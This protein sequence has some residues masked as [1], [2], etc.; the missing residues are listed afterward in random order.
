MNSVSPRHNRLKSLMPLIA[1]LACAAAQVHAQQGPELSGYQ[2]LPFTLSNAKSRIVPEDLDG[3]GL[4]DILTADEHLLSVYFQNADGQKPFDFSQADAVLAL[5]GNA[6]GW[7]I[8]KLPGHEN[9]GGKRVLALLE[10]QQVQAWTISAE[11]FGDAETV[12]GSVSG[13]LPSGA[14]PLGFVRDINGDGLNDLIV[15]GPS[16]LQLYL[17]TPEGDYGDS[18]QIQSRMINYARLS[19]GENLASRVGQR[20]RIPQMNIRDVNN[21]HRK[22]LIARSEARVDVFLAD[23]KGHFPTGANYS[24]DLQALKDRVGEVDFDKLDYSNLSGVLSHTYDVQL[25]DVDGDNIE[26]LLMREG[27]KL[28]LFGGTASGMDMQKP[29]QILKSSGNVL[30]TL[31]RDEDEDGLK[32]LWL[33]RVQNV[34][35]GN[36]FLWLAVSGSIDIETYVYKNQGERFASR[37]HRK[38]TVSV[39]FP[40]ILRSMDMVNGAMEPENDTAVIRSVRAQLDDENSAEDLAVLR[41][42]SLAV[43]MNAIENDKSEHFLGLSNY[44]R[45]KDR[46]VYDLGKVL[47]NPAIGGNR[48]LEAVQGHEADFDI[49]YASEKLQIDLSRADLQAWDMNG[50]GRDDF[51]VLSERDEDSV[52]GFLLLSR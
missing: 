4:K 23:S 36:L 52:S 37:P 14:Y 50:D 30:G 10:G 33:V 13:F 35:L 1:V 51:F 20:V 18:L 12:L 8:D 15:P 24:I 21:D 16:E 44:S 46:Y 28:T 3:D 41:Q 11:G 39:K 49:R 17:Q 26:D 32:D 45:D 43:F 29:R 25:E 27:G 40:S 7:A 31:L 2:S 19:P 47:E 48:D 9:Q 5:P 42:Q 38:V 6:T 22:D 34:S